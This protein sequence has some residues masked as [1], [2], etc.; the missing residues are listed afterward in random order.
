MVTKRQEL[1]AILPRFLYV[2]KPTLKDHQKSILTTYWRFF[3]KDGSFFSKGLFHQ[4]FQRL[5]F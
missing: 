4:P 2:S 3:R 5:S 1:V